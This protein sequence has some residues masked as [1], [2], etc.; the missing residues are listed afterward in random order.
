M[1][2]YQYLR[3]YNVDI[4]FTITK[5]LESQIW[6]DDK[7]SN[8]NLDSNNNA[9]IN[10]WIVKRYSNEITHYLAYFS[11]YLKEEDK[12]EFILFFRNYQ[13]QMLM[14]MEEYLKKEQNTVKNL[15]D[16]YESNNLL[17]S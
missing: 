12:E 9:L 10:Y 7:F 14:L 17:I 4:L 13:K 15:M 16:E 2:K 5:D 11:K 1:K 3:Y 6:F 8:L